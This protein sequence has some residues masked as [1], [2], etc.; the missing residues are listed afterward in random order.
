M[1]KQPIISRFFK[2]VKK[3][4]NDAIELSVSA[5]SAMPEP[6][7]I[8]ISNEVKDDRVS[9]DLLRSG[10]S[11]DTETRN[12]SIHVT[13]LN[14]TELSNPTDDLITEEDEI[15]KET[16]KVENIS[17]GQR[18]STFLKTLNNI[19][20]K[21]KRVTNEH[22]DEIDEP[23]TEAAEG[24][25]NTKKSKKT[26]TDQLTPLDKQIKD[27]KIKNMDKVLIVRVGYKYK[28]FAEDAIIVSQL[29]HIMLIPG[30]L[31]IDGSNPQDKNYK[32]FAYCS[33]PD[34]RLKVH[35]ENLVHHNL[36]V[37]IV[38]QTETSAIKKVLPSS[39]SSS[40]FERQI[41]GVFTKATFGVNST[42]TNLR[43]KFVLGHNNSIWILKL[44]L[45]INELNLKNNDLFEF[46]LI[47]VNLNSGEV[48]YDSFT[49]PINRLEKFETRLLH[50]NP[51]E[52]LTTEE[53]PE[54]ISKKLKG[55][56]CSIIKQSKDIPNDIV[57]TKELDEIVK[58]NDMKDVFR[59]LLYH[60][61]FYLTEYNN[62]NILK[63]PTN[64]KHF[65]TNS[66]FTLDK[67][68]IQSLDIFSN[69]CGKGSL[70]WLLDHTRTAFG[71]RQLRDWVLHPLTNQV[72]IEERLNSIEAL[73]T[74]IENIFFDSLNNL[75]KNTPDIL[76][77]IN[78]I[79]YGITSRKEVYYFLKQMKQFYDHFQVHNEFLS[80]EVINENGLIN[81]KSPFLFNLFKTINENLLTSRIPE[82]LA[83]INI[84]A[85][86]DKD[87]KIQVCE[88]FNLNNYCNSE[89]MTSIQREIGSI[90]NELQE[91]LQNIKNIL[92]RPHLSFKDETEYL[93]E[94]RNTQVKGIPADW[95]V[96]N[97][98]KMISRYQTP[99]TKL[100]C[101]K[102]QFQN[103]LLYN[104]ANSEYLSFVKCINKEYT[105][106][107]QIIS[108]FGVY[109]ALL[110]LS[111]TSNYTNYVRPKFTD[112]PQYIQA[113]NSRNPIIE[114]L[115]LNYVPN[116]VTIS[117][118]EGSFLIITGPNMGG[119]SSY[120]RQVALLII[121]SQ[122]GSFVPADVLEISIF[123]NVLTRIGAY[124][125]L[126]QG[127]STFKVELQ[128]ILHIIKN[129]TEN[130]LLLLDEVGR[131]TSTKDGQAISWSLIN[132]FV[133]LPSCPVV[134]FTT[135]YSNLTKN[136]S[137]KVIQNYYMDFVER[138][139][140]GESWTTVVFLY[141][142]K[143]GLTDNSYGLNVAK[144]AQIDARIINEAHSA[145]E[146]MRDEEEIEPKLNVIY[147]MKNI[148]SSS[149]D[150][151]E[152]VSSLI[153]LIDSTT[154][155]EE[156]SK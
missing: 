109:D 10:S 60:L 134:L 83:M 19:M 80:S 4:K 34:I 136:L 93:I 98:T 78:R 25:Y 148:L 87:P 154:N 20:S 88:F 43:E 14:D 110:S 37:A 17:N 119:K 84:S 6:I 51:V 5:N 70:F 66:S 29:L 81:K 147:T 137:S 145:S 71:S 122:I 76:K 156:N 49:E 127:Q 77:T 85:V 90:K 73:V 13:S 103:E 40:V 139:L 142:L 48:V 146:T 135:H 39:K 118:K 24:S 132:Y 149:L 143:K 133:T 112:V 36:K 11:E 7:L 114:S 61:Y 99:K 131:G 33:F 123:D 38:E 108:N 94:V 138:K 91:E 53:F 32:Q 67:N 75:L 30:K 129:S 69:D 8:D 52:V 57:P 79:S 126:L 115:N 65:L 105:K 3:S 101:E 111:A 46:F 41:T 125:N 12:S 144:L 86:L 22:I 50:L 63:L 21:R 27:I 45:V 68:T 107:H 64:Y 151:A 82:L 42:F 72:L 121:L 62:Q 31:S 55:K 56:E 120:I 47:S 35:L 100:L 59:S 28:C 152:K 153:T 102:L 113:S 141:K 16:D 116:N 2:S 104:E 130:S 54:L 15:I 58:G 128:E 124:D 140:E 155:E 89:N 95:V 9:S 74:E 150:N 18:S 44:N 117:Q 106:L 97:R 1:S 96:V 23:S 92:K 26:N